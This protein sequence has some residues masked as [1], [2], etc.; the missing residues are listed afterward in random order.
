MQTGH[1]T[2]R[3]TPETVRFMADAARFGQF[4]AILAQAVADAVPDRGHICDAGCGTGWLSRALTRYFP[5]VTAADVSAEALS[6]LRAAPLPR[7]LEILQADLFTY[8][9]PVPFDAMVFCFFGS[10][11][12]TLA[13][14]RRCCCGT[15]VL[16]KR[17]RAARQFSGGAPHQNTTRSTEDAL[18]ALGLPFRLRSLRVEMGQPLRTEADAIRFARAYSAAP[19][20]LDPEAVLARLR[21]IPDDPEFRFF[22]PREREIGLIALDTASLCDR[23]L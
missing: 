13:I 7:G 4:P 19:A 9:P 16:L 21:P 14:A 3:W 23:S 22:L 6:A 8:T 5:A 20:Q 17:S 12:Q 2:Y 15:L 1:N 10:L 18:N 11:A